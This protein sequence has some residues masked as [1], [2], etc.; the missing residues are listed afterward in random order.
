MRGGLD[1]EKYD[2]AYQRPRPGT[3]RILNYF[4]PHRRKVVVVAICITSWRCLGAA[5]PIDHRQQPERRTGGGRAFRRCWWR[6]CWWPAW[7]LGA[8]RVRRYLT[9]QVIAD[10]VNAMRNDAFA[11]AMRQDMSFLRRVLFRPHRQPHHQRHAGV[12]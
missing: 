6:W 11:A 12:W 7:A 4:R 9:T 2:R 10:V 1:A 5:V 3:L 8:D